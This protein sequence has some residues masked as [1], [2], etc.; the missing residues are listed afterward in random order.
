L[1]VLVVVIVL[2]VRAVVAHVVGRL[3]SFPTALLDFVE[4]HEL[5][6]FLS[7]LGVLLQNLARGQRIAPRS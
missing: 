4:Q 6:D 5:D 1:I 7:L 2:L 3:S